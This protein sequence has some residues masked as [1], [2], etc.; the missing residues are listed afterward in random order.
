MFV[1]ED[2]TVEELMASA[3]FQRHRRAVVRCADGQ[4]GILSATAIER[5]IRARRMLEERDLDGTKPH[6]R[7]IAGA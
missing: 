2:I 1:D 7:S 3:G 6:P 4:V 5:A